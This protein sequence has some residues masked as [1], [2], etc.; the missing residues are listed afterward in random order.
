MRIPSN[1]VADIFRFAHSELEDL[2][3]KEEVESLMFI[4]FEEYLGWN[5]AKVL[6]DREKNINQSDLLKFN[7]GI[8]DIKKGKPV[9][10]VIGK[11][12]F[13]GEDFLV[14]KH[15]LIP[16][17]ETEELVSLIIKENNQK[18]NLSIL[19]I[20]TGSGCIAITLAK[21]LNGSKV[22]AMDISQ[23]ALEM[24]KENHRRFDV[25]ISFLEMDILNPEK[26]FV[27]KFD[28]I[29]SNPPYVCD[30]E[31]TLM[32][33]N[34]LDYEPHTALFVDDCEPL[35]FYD[36]IADFAKKH[37]EKEGILYFEIN[38]RFGTEMNFL[39]SQK[40]F[41]SSI[42]QDINGKNRICK[43]VLLEF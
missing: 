32:K 14:N 26:S 39:L 17:P 11:S 30:S 42:I 15:T 37:L 40:G 22:I 43:A 5:K 20:G 29:V 31:K 9:Q 38:E 19:D 27:Q 33:K 10:Y 1:K 6:S 8:K 4:F 28:I 13:Y 3:S 25:D 23:N 36:K 16:R 35:I 2:Y 21:H 41:N 7:F 12:Y 34:V 18:N 24:A